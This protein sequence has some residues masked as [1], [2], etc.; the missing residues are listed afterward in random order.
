[1]KTFLNEAKPYLVGAMIALV[2]G[3]GTVLVGKAHY[4][5][6]VVWKMEEILKNSKVPF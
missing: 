5:L 4:Y 3:G 6:R 2:L 1:M